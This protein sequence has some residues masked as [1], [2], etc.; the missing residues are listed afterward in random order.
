[1][2]KNERKRRKKRL[3]EEKREA[4]HRLYLAEKAKDVFPKIVINPT[5]GDDRLV[6]HIEKIVANLDLS[7]PKVLSPGMQLILRFVRSRG[8]D[9]MRAASQKL[10]KHTDEP[11]AWL[12][13][14]TDVR[15]AVGQQILL[16]L[17]RAYQDS[18]LPFNYFDVQL[19]DRT[20]EITFEFLPSKIDK[21]GRVYL[22]PTATTV[23]FDGHNWPVGFSLHA[24]E[25][26]CERMAFTKPVKFTQFQVFKTYFNTCRWFESLQLDKGT[27]AF[28]MYMPLGEPGV[29]TFDTYVSK[30]A[31]LSP[32]AQG[33]RLGYL[34]GYCPVD[35]RLGRAVAKTCLPPGY[36]GTPEDRLVRSARI[37]THLRRQ[38][39]NAAQNNT[40]DRV[41]AGN[42]EVIRWY[43]ENGVPQVREMPPGMFFG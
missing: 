22:P 9:G 43:H 12:Q 1:M 24:I 31:Q 26:A 20:L 38:L 40:L 35:F 21:H 39:L 7:D 15:M 4:K 32:N 34:M 29:A 19:V 25:R 3:R 42:H 18:S 17:P 11:K 41:L 5:N 13:A 14:S 37:D 6:R 27:H 30:V 23:R 2:D 8:R 33:W 16:G 36:A 10:L 28:A